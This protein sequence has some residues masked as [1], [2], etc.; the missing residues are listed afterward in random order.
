VP[1]A[2][3]AW[4]RYLVPLTLLAFIACLPMLWIAWRWPAPVDVQH[5]RM[6]MRVTYAL[7]S[8]AWIWQIWLVAGVAPAVRSLAEGRPISQGRALTRGLRGLATKLIPVVI[9]IFA[10]VLGSVALVVPGVLLLILLSTTGASASH[11]EA[12]SV[13]RANMKRLAITIAV[14][15]VGALVIAFACQIA[16][17]P[18]IGKKVAAAKLL[19]IVAFTRIVAL[20]LTAYAPVAACAIAAATARRVR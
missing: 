3:R 10:I 9:A 6:Q 20:S 14:I 1:L 17:V 12:I 11:T 13:A 19:P 7:A 2:L 5:A 16:I 4:L 8:T 18:S 15:I